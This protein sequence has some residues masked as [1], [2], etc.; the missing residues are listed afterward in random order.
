MR[1]Y[2]IRA[3]VAAALVL[4]APL[5]LAQATSTVEQRLQK[6]EAEQ[7][8]MKRQIEERDARIRELEGK[9]GESPQ[10][11]AA[12]QPAPVPSAPA[13]A[14]L[15]P[16][17]PVPVETV[18]SAEARIEEDRRPTPS[19][20]ETWG[21]YD[22]G[23]GFLVARTKAGE[24]DISA[25][26]MGRYLDQ[27]DSDGVFT[28]H[29]G[30]QRT[31]DGREDIFSHRILIWLK[32]WLVDPKLT[33]AITLWTVNT[34]DQDAIFANLG[35]SFNKHFNL[36]VGIV[37]NPGSRSLQ[38]SHPFWLGNDRV[39]ADEFFRPYFGQGLY[40]NGEIT[41]GLFYQ[42]VLSNSNSA[43]GVKASDLDRKFTRGGSLWWMPTTKEFGPRGAYGD[44]EWH[45]DVATRF[46]ISTIF[47]PEQSYADAGKNPGNTTLRLAD[48]VNLFETGSL[49]PGVTIRNADYSVA[50]GGCRREV[51]RHLPAGR[52]LR[53]PPGQL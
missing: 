52:I 14:Q 29:L 6:L 9:L 12:Q 18:A 4:P 10:P 7:S 19:G 46:G 27:N 16:V 42:A 53:A 37:G 47:S 30:N 25:Y 5:A 11:A 51:S 33:Y 20:H 13:P 24:L 28:D 40:A 50:V 23:L 8:A 1:S 36:Y 43:L 41:P 44:W 39:M 31:V 49:A 17:V 38:G 3:A 48:S 21:V 26:A 35:Y 32:G 22:P 34:T 15:A 2:M 45:E